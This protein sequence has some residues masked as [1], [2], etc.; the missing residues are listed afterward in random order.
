MPYIVTPPPAVPGALLDSTLTDLAF[1]Y[2]PEYVRSDDDGTLYGLLGAVCSQADRSV[3]WL[4]DPAAVADPWQAQPDQLDWLAAVS[5]VDLT[6]VP[7]D[8]RR[9]FIA[10]DI[11]R[12]RGSLAALQYRVGQTLTGG[13]AVEVVCPYLG[14]V[15]RISVTTYASQTPDPTATTAA[16]LAEIPA[17]MRATIVTN[18]AGQSYANM[19]ADYATYGVMAA[20]NKTY[21]TLSQE[22]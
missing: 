21:G 11:T 22:I 2:L 19:A 5:G 9:A 3:A 15:N 4:S 18:A 17:W 16:I 20:T 8:N 1:D 7:N 6:S 13:K 10:S 14:D 12:N